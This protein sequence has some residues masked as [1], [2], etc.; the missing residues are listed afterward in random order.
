MK[1]IRLCYQ[2]VDFGE[3]DIHIRT[4]RDKQQYFDPEGAAAKIGISSAAWPLFGVVWDSGYFLADIMVDYPIRGKRILEVGCGIGLASLVLNH[5][6]ADITATDHHPEAQAFLDRNTL[7][8]HDRNISFVR[9][10]W[11]DN[12]TQALGCFN[13]IIGSD[14]LYEEEQA[15]MLALFIHR[16]SELHCN[17]LIID[18]GRGHSAKFKRNMNDLGFR[19]SAEQHRASNEASKPFSGKILSFA[20]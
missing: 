1:P 20:R 5:R 2:T 6:G 13:L 14:L 10:G 11:N 4:L 16:Y 19:F 3:F 9:V 17:V 7:L 18:P 12:V 8:N 15:K